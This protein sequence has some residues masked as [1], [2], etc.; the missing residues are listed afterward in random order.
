M[1]LKTCGYGVP[2]L[3]KALE[4]ARNSLTLVAEDAIQPSRNKGGKEG[5]PG[6]M[7]EMLFN[8]LSWSEKELFELGGAKV[9]LRVT[10]SYF[11]EPGPGRRGWK[12]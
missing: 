6:L 11:V 9:T 10:L 1:L 2:D 5:S 8:E 12:D 4:S 3:L 7:N